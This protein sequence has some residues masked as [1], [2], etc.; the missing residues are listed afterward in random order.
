ML[1]RCF[2]Q[3]GTEGSWR[4]RWRWACN[5]SINIIRTHLFAA[6]NS[7]RS[8]V[9]TRNL[10][11]A[12]LTFIVGTDRACSGGLLQWSHSHVSA[13]KLSKTISKWLCFDYYSVHWFKTVC[14]ASSS[15]STAVTTPAS[16]GHESIKKV[17]V[18][19]PTNSKTPRWDHCLSM[20]ALL[21]YCH[22]NLFAI[23][24]MCE[25]P[26]TTTSEFAAVFKNL[27]TATLDVSSPIVCPS[28]TG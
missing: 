23:K 24:Y 1:L 25:H 7:T 21:M 9:S 22:R 13:L 27:D 15:S 5:S 6:C 20:T 18:M 28:C 11:W 26:K 12:S 16:I 17:G 4:S 14:A 8:T 2:L 3:T 19:R 10:L